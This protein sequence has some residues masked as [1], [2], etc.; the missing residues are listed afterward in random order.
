MKKFLSVLCTTILVLSLAGI[1][2]AATYEFSPNDGWGDPDDLWDLDHWRYYTWGTNWTVPED[3]TIVGASL[4]FDS[5]RNWNDSSNVLYVH[6]F[7]NIDLPG[8]PDPNREIEIGNSIVREY[9]DS[10][11]EQ[12]DAFDGQGTLL[13]TWENLPSTPD[14]IL[15]NFDDTEITALTSYVAD[16]KFGFGFDPD[17]HFYNSGIKLTIKTVNDPVVPEPSTILLVGLGLV[18]LIGFGRKRIKK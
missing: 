4:F 17:C 12:V 11:R 3:E 10:A 2:G 15:Y 5:I 14:D 1:A 16:G 13:N 9:E 6:L 7:D 8:L 18:G